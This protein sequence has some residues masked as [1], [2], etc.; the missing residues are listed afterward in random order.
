MVQGILQIAKNGKDET[1][2]PRAISALIHQSNVV[3][4]KK[5]LEQLPQRIQAEYTSRTPCP[6]PSPTN[7]T[8]I[9]AMSSFLRA[10]DSSIGLTLT[11]KLATSEYIAVN[12]PGAGTCGAAG[13]LIGLI[14]HTSEPLELAIREVGCKVITTHIDT[15]TTSIEE[16]QKKACRLGILRQEFGLAEAYSEEEWAINIRMRDYSLEVSE[17]S[18]IAKALGVK[19][20]VF[21][22]NPDGLP[23]PQLH[24]DL[25]GDVTVQ[26][27]HKG[28]GPKGGHYAAVIKQGLSQAPLSSEELINRIKKIITEETNLELG[29]T[30]KAQL[31]SDT[32]GSYAPPGQVVTTV[33]R[34]I[35]YIREYC[36]T[37]IREQPPLARHAY[38]TRWS[39]GR[40]RSAWNKPLTMFN[41]SNSQATT[42]TVEKCI[43]FNRGNCQKTNCRFLHD[44]AQCRYEVQY[45]KCNRGEQCRFEHSATAN[46]RICRYHLRGNCY[47]GDSCNFEHKELEKGGCW[48]GYSQHCP[49][50]QSCR[51]KHIDTLPR[52]P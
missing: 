14:G 47:R 12:T 37:I 3:L 43:D 45:G 10:N 13:F 52:A 39:E 7:T 51:Y 29:K 23:E 15:C 30:D 24:G 34:H 4:T 18:S 5:A 48:F 32:L 2:G 6:C 49:H 1:G 11:Q 8:V 40:A 41:E 19:L 28:I 16:T 44:K 46:K 22:N 33:H 50:G 27:I 20:K 38:Q 42:V 26:L 21:V 31:N 25:D 36:N 17:L 35:G 9:H